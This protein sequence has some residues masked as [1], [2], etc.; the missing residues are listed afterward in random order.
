MFLAQK[1]QVSYVRQASLPAQPD[2][3]GVHVFPL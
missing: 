2:S 3:G 1:L